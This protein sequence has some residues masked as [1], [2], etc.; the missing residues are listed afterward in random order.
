[1]FYRPALAMSL[2]LSP[3]LTDASKYTFP[4]SADKHI[5]EANLESTKSELCDIWSRSPKTD[6][7]EPN[8]SLCNP[9]K[10]GR[11]YCCTDNSRC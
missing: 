9:S 8:K 7:R 1:M 2:L 4:K 3:Y 5:N 11:K 6:S 10:M